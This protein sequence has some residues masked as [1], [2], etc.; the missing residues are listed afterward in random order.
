VASVEVTVTAMELAE[1]LVHELVAYTVMFP[2]AAVQ[3]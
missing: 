3:P 2:F 1:V